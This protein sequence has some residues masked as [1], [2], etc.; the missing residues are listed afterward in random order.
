MDK[1][2]ICVVGGGTM[3]RGIAYAAALGGF[4]VRL[5]DVTRDILEAARENLGLHS[6][7]QIR[8]ALLER[9]GGIS[10]IPWSTE[11]TPRAR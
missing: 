1:N 5:V 3:G 11:P 6:L 9:T 7:D 8:F 10:I 2:T 4:Q